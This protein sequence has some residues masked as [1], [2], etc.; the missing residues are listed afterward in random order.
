MI[1]KGILKKC[2]IFL[3]FKMQKIIQVL[4]KIRWKNSKNLSYIR[5]GII[6]SLLPWDKEKLKSVPSNYEISLS[7]LDKVVRSRN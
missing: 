1:V 3:I 2:L 4:I 6:M 5:K 7:V